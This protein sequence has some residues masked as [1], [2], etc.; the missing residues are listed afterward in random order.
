MDELDDAFKAYDIHSFSEWPLIAR[1][2]FEYEARKKQQARELDICLG[3]DAKRA[4]HRTNLQRILQTMLRQASKDLLQK[5]TSEAYRCVHDCVQ[6]DLEMDAEIIARV[7]D[8]PLYFACTTF[9]IQ[10]V[11]KTLF[12]PAEIQDIADDFARRV[13]AE[14]PSDNAV[15]GM[16]SCSF[17]FSDSEKLQPSYA[18][19]RWSRTKF[20]E[21][22][23][24]PVSSMWA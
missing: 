17:R 1:I 23:R 12:K 11:L 2:A 13:N 24:A 21:D 10:Q 6:F 4:E 7:A 19:V 15:F 3:S 16:F 9:G 20:S 5:I 18:C 22:F 8:A 14:R